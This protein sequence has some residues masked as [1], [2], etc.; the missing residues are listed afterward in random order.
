MLKDKREFLLAMFAT[1]I[2]GQ[3][4]WLKPKQIF[5]RAEALVNEHEETLKRWKDEA[6]KPNVKICKD[7]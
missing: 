7:M 4:T 2:E 6:E 3:G 5:E 1:A